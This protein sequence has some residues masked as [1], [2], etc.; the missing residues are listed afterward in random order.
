VVEVEPA[1]DDPKLLRG[2]ASRIV[3]ASPRRVE[4]PCPY[5]AKCGG[6]HYQHA[7]YEDQVR[8][9]A[10]ILVE[11]LR[12]IGKLTPPDPEVV[13]GE[14]W[15]YRNRVQFKVVKRGKEF[16]LGYLEAASNRLVDL[17]KCPIA[18]PAINDL[19]PQI[20]ELGIRPDFPNGPSEIEIVDGAGE[21]LITVRSE[22]RFPETLV[23]A[24]RERLPALV[25]LARADAQGGF[26]RLWGR[27]FAICRAARF[28]F[29][30]SHGVFFQVNRFL[31]DSLAEIATRHLDGNSAF[32]LY[33]GAGYFTIPLARKFSKVTAVEANPAAVRDLRA[34]CTRA[35]FDHVDAQRAS[36]SEFLA[37]HRSKPDVVLV[38]PPRAGLDKGVAR[39][40]AAV[41]SP[42]IVY[43]SC[44]PPTL[45]RDLAALTAADYRIEKI[46]MVDLFPQTFHIEAVVILRR[47]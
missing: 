42:A 44:D 8:F 15:Q 41:E 36:I 31:A 19:I 4:A 45:A 28:D 12:R 17:E 38:D 29:R 30:V 1:R 5:F 24:F 9:K 2:R 7:P 11:T 32:D 23:S 22:G 10:E 40:L 20:K 14:P 34:N 21:I 27:G 35:Q 33:A 37:Q 47:P 43:V 13:S 25:S 6:C 46:Y 18:S 26:F 16:H 39:R 3:D